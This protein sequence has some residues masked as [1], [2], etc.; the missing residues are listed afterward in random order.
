MKLGISIDNSIL[1]LGIFVWTYVG[2]GITVA[3]TW[4]E[5]FFYPEKKFRVWIAKS[6][7]KG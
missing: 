4:M 3:W 6:E 1:G 7:R 2:W 5:I